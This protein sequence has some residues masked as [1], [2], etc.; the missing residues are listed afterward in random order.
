MLQGDRGQ[1]W[2]LRSAQGAGSSARVTPYYPQHY[3]DVLLEEQSQ[4]PQRNC[5]RS[6]VRKGLACYD[7]YER[8]TLWRKDRPHTMYAPGG[9]VSAAHGVALQTT[10]RDLASWPRFLAVFTATQ[11]ESISLVS[12]A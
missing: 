3:Y 11:P 4:A 10:V 9:G 8:W 12:A 5:P 2:E 1:S 7:S 6:P